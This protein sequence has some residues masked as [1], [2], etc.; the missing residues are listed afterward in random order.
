M[1]VFQKGQPL[2]ILVNSKTLQTH[3]STLPCCV[4]IQRIMLK[5][6]ALSF[7]RLILLHLSPR[8][9]HKEPNCWKQS[10]EI[11][12][13]IIFYQ[14]IHGFV[15]PPGSFSPCSTCNPITKNYHRWPNSSMK[16]FLNSNSRLSPYLPRSKFLLNA[17]SKQARATVKLTAQSSSINSAMPSIIWYLRCHLAELNLA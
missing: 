3:L 1:H 11:V 4:Q 8:F 9:P 12:I 17:S 13:F 5:P 15:H 6:N 7:R 10:L 14:K 2:K 16:F